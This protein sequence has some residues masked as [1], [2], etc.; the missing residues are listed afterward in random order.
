MKLMNDGDQ[1][2]PEKPILY[3][4]EPEEFEQIPQKWG[5][6]KVGD[7]KVLKLRISSDINVIKVQL[8]TTNGDN[9]GKPKR[10]K[11]S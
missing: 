8:K 4:I 7:D 10:L 3:F 1:D 2:W 5:P 11:L 6:V 9:I